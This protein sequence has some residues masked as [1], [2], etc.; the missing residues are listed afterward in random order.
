LIY[1]N[2]LP[3][4]INSIP[5]LFAG[6]TCI[7]KENLNQLEAKLYSEI[8]DLLLWCTANKLTINSTKYNKLIIIPPKTN[9][10][11][12]NFNI[13]VKNEVIPDTITV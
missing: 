11:I 4:A 9:S 1:I 2:G 7:T 3:N 10:K 6:D 13:L 8:R 12:A 5:R